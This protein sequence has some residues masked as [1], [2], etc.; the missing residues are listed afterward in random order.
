M[1][2]QDN[3]Y[4][5]VEKNTWWRIKASC[6]LSPGCKLESPGELSQHGQCQG[7]AL[8]QGP[9]LLFWVHQGRWRA[10]QLAGSG[11][12]PANSS[13]LQQLS[14]T[15][16]LATVL[17][18]GLGG[19]ERELPPGGILLSVILQ[20]LIFSI[21]CKMQHPSLT[22]TLVYLCLRIRIGISLDELT[23]LT[24]VIR[25]CVEQCF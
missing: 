10:L 1:E 21:S 8:G 19:G 15:R 12:L 7:W 3:V 23:S 5:N 14:Q 20:S 22:S 18:C 4:C 2:A 16:H 6:F 25:L 13:G 9:R 11:P 24:L 17:N